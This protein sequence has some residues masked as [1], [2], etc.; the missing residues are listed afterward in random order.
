[1]A[2]GLASS[3]SSGAVAYATSLSGP[4]IFDD[5]GSVVENTTIRELGPAALHPDRESPTA[6]R[7]LVNLTFAINYAIG[8]LNVS[9]YHVANIAIH[10]LCSLV[11]FGLVLAHAR[12]AA[13]PRV[14][15]ANT[16][17]TL[18][19]AVALLWVVHPL[20]SEAVDYITQRTESLMAL[21]YLLTVYCALRAAVGPAKAG[22][23][24]QA[25]GPAKPDAPYCPGRSRRLSRARWGWRARSR[26]SPRR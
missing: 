6:G 17:P 14:R 16:R 22:P 24:V 23:H 15:S 20:N 9:G 7:P 8:G 13:H 10:L 25:A 2:A 12:S 18:A 5:D 21:F 19:F 1:V 4:F 11:L 3:R 26:W